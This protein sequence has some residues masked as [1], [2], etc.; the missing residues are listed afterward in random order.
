MRN[1]NNHTK[2]D[3]ILENERLVKDKN[4]ME[5]KL[6]TIKAIKQSNIPEVKPI[7]NSYFSRNNLIFRA[8]LT[9]L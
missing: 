7:T 3:L 4:L 2:S 9:T 6:A 5:L 8:I 1:F